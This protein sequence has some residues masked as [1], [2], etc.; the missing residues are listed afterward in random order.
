MRLIFF[1]VPA[2][3]FAIWALFAVS[4]HDSGTPAAPGPALVPEL[5]AGALIAVGLVLLARAASGI[6][7]APPRPLPGR[8]RLGLLVVLIVVLLLPEI[9]MLYGRVPVIAT[10]AE[11]FA[12][13]TL[14]AGSADRLALAWLRWTLA[15]AV[16]VVA[17]GEGALAGVVSLLVGLLIALAGVDAKTGI[18]RMIRLEGLMEDAPYAVE[19]GVLLLMMACRINPLPAVLGYLGGLRAEAMFQSALRDTKGDLPLALA[20]GSIAPAALAAIAVI[21][22]VLAWYR[23]P[24]RG[25]REAPRVVA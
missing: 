4:P 25:E 18:A 11:W 21:V 24:W 15:I 13:A 20:G 14:A 12:E 6:A 17:A 10:I 16:G 5:V 9:V 1:A 7:T 22:G 3:A 8:L 23:W 19:I 2:V